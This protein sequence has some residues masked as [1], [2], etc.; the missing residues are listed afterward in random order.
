MIALTHTTYDDLYRQMQ[1]ELT[2]RDR[3]R[4]RSASRDAERRLA[5][6][7]RH[8]HLLPLENVAVLPVTY[9][10]W[11]WPRF[12][13]EVKYQELRYTL[14]LFPPRGT[15]EEKLRIILEERSRRVHHI[16]SNLEL[17]TYLRNGR[18]DLDGELFTRDPA[19]A[20]KNSD[21]IAALWAFDRYELYIEERFPRL[22]IG[23]LVQEPVMARPR[24]PYS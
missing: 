11:H 9:W 17:F 18:I 15:R 7:W 23:V 4:G 14:G 3:H 22:S 21:W 8:R 19:I 5:I 24:K 1:T 16:R 13:S 20:A 6:A 2:Q 10:R 12:E